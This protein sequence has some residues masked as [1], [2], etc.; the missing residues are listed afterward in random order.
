MNNQEAINLTTYIQQTAALNQL[1]IP[2]ECEAG[3]VANFQRIAKIA[4]QVMEFPLPENIAAAPKFD[5]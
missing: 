3:V 5:P 4:Q 1:P 2:P